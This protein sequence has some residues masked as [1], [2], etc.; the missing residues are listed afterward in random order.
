[1]FN[2]SSGIQERR[3]KLASNN[4]CCT[5]VGAQAGDN[6][7]SNTELDQNSTSFRHSSR[8]KNI[9]DNTALAEIP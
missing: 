4:D 3:L 5:A 7:K 8:F 6:L 2:L 1:M 9:L